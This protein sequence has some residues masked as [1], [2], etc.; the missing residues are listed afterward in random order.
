[1]IRIVFNSLYLFIGRPE[2]TD[3]SYP[4][5]NRLVWPESSYRRPRSAPR[6]RLIIARGWRRS[7]A[8][9]CS[10]IKMIRELGLDRLCANA[11]WRI[12]SLNPTRKVKKSKSIQHI[13][14]VIRKIRIE[15]ANSYRWNPSRTTPREFRFYVGT[16]RDYM[17]AARKGE[18]IVQCT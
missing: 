13:T 1:M 12:N 9:G 7:Q 5:D 3:K 15:E 6:C 16:R 4:G 10:P 11:D 17:L 8:F 18:G 2:T 14:A